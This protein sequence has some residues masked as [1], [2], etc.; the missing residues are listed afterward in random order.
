[1]HDIHN[2]V[3][4]LWLP[5]ADFGNYFPWL[6]FGHIVMAFFLTLLCA[7]FVPGGGASA[8]AG[9]GILLALVYIGNNFI[10]YAVQPVTTNLLGG[11]LGRDVLMFAIC[12]GII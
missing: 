11:R 6:I 7:K 12:G 4:A 10:I 2:E 8:C 5:E 1:M 9:L 3:P